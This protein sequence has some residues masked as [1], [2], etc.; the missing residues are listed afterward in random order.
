MSHKKASKKIYKSNLPRLSNKQMKKLCP[1]VPPLATNLAL[2][3]S[4]F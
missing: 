3:I 1:F 4:E 2:I